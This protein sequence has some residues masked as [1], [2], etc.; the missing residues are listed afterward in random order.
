MGLCCPAK[1]DPRAIFVPWSCNTLLLEIGRGAFA[2]GVLP[3]GLPR[4][5]MR[6]GRGAL[7]VEGTPAFLGGP[8]LGQI[9]LI[10]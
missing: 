8:S 5:L 4:M 10:S 1:I 7:L 6:G 3:G 2:A 9:S